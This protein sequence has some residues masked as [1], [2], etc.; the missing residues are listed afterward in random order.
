MPLLS[1][2]FSEIKLWD[3]QLWN[4]KLQNCFKWKFRLQS[5]KPYLGP[6]KVERNK[7]K[8]EKWNLKLYL[9]LTPKKILIITYWN[10]IPAIVKFLS[11]HY[12]IFSF[13]G[14][15]FLPNYLDSSR[16]FVSTTFFGERFYEHCFLCFLLT[17]ILCLYERNHQE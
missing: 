15:L 8:I 9:T 14:L 12:F 2:D 11:I 7:R 10:L 1:K 3:S 6:L 17:F 16:S 4:R 5:S 13:R